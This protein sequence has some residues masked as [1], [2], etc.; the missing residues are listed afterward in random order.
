MSN[1]YT[2]QIR[3]IELYGYGFETENRIGLN[4][5]QIWSPNPKRNTKSGQN[6]VFIGSI[7]HLGI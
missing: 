1:T 3:A 2:T 4:G 6:T 5:E 7:L